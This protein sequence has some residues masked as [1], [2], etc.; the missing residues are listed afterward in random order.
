PIVYASAQGMVWKLRYSAGINWQL[1]RIGY[2]D[3]LA[4]VKN[5]NTQ[6]AIN[7]TVQLMMPFGAK[8]NHAVM[9]SYK[10]TLNEIP[11]TAI[12]SVVDW[13]DAYNYTVGNPGLKAQ[14]AD[15]I[16]AGLSLFRNKINIT[17]IYSHSHDRIYWQT[18]QSTDNPDV[19]YTMPVNISGQSVWGLGAEWIEAPLKWWKFKLSGRIEITPENTTLGNIHYGKTCVK[20]YFFFNNDF[21]FANSWGG[22]LNLNF[23]PTYTTL[24][25]TYHAVYNIDARIYKS[26]LKENLQV[27][28]EFT[29]IGNRRKLDRKVEQKK[30]TYKLTSPVQ[31]VGLS[32]TWNFAGGKEVDVNVIDGIQ[33]YHEIKD[34]R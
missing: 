25:R 4:N 20:E 27:A 8:M 6:W 11:Y 17:A 22:M 1:N 32:L 7:P 21:R 34:N 3:K 9:M 29:P 12:S 31:Y 14:S 28:L 26:L 15:M 10:R 23:E 2:H 24:D 5:H 19:F 30:I 13:L 18:F 16:M 33:N